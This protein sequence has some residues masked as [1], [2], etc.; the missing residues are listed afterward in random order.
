[1]GIARRTGYLLSESSASLAGSA[2]A[3]MLRMRP[4]PT[5]KRS[6]PMSSPSRNASTP[7]S[8]HHLVDGPDRGLPA[9]LRRPELVEAEPAHD[10]DEPAAYVLEEVDLVFRFLEPEGETAAMERAGLRVTARFD[11]SP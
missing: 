11:R 8:P 3:W 9:V 10:H 4:L 1:V 6:T 7:G 2:M 5:P